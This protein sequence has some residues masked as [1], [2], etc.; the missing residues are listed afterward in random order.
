LP[1]DT[2]GA[3]TGGQLL[4]VMTVAAVSTV[5]VAEPTVAVAATAAVAVVAFMTGRFVLVPGW[6]FLRVAAAA[7]VALAVF[8]V[9][10]LVEARASPIVAAEG[11]AAAAGDRYGTPGAKSENRSG[12]KCRQT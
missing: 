1:A 10:V 7:T 5:L 8:A 6:F 9:V 2:T 4:V 3:I 12:K 11:E